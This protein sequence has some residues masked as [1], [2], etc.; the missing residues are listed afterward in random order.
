MTT[1]GAARRIEADAKSMRDMFRSADI[2][3]LLM[4][5]LQITRDEDLMMEAS[6]FIRGSWDFSVRMPPELT[7]RIIDRLASALERPDGLDRAKEPVPNDLLRRMM[8]LAVGQEVAEEYLPMARQQMG[9]DAPSV[10]DVLAAVP[11]S[12]KRAAAFPVVVIGAGLSGICAGIALKQAG[13]P[14][15]IIEKNDEVGGTW[16]ENVYPGAGVDTPSHF[17]SFSFDQKHDWT[18]FFPKRDEMYGYFRQLA[19]KHDLRSNIRFKTE[20]VDAVFD[21]AKSAWTVRCRAQAG[22]VECITARAVISAVG[23]LNRPSIPAIEGLDTFKGAKFHTAVWDKSQNISGKRVAMIGS[24][25]SAIQA[26]PK[27]AQEASHL[28]VFQRSPHWVVANPNYHRQINDDLQWVLKSVPFYA[29]WNR[30]RLFWSVADGIWPACVVDDSWSSP[31]SSV[32]ALSDRYRRHMT[33]YIESEVGDDPDLL[34][35]VIPN[36]PPYGKRMLVDTHWFR[37]LRRDNVSLVDTPIARIAENGIVTADGTLHEADILV[38][39]TGFKVSQML[40]PMEIRG[41]NGRSLNDAWN[42]DDPRAYLG[43][44]VPNFPN[45]FLLFGPNTGLS[46]GGSVIF[47]TERQVRYI[48][49]CLRELI[50][51]DKQV[52]EIKDDVF[53][54]YNVKVDEILNKTVWAHHKVH[55][56]YKNARGRVFFNSPWRLVDYWKLTDKPELDDYLIN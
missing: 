24:G 27:I 2:T 31:D 25:A 22:E 46:H 9:F 54:D 56:W 35:K 19:D 12:E 7:D 29:Q 50:E 20:V 14:F 13:L 4:V 39:A 38:L 40:S 47:H 51:N 10:K 43:M 11:L 45:F 55:S 5:L 26:G 17:Y 42:G 6:P 28:T 52:I 37:M 21:E 16:Y 53:N 3:C 1:N 34:A 30:F 32:N 41:R 49:Q 44:T 36:Y 18:T 15:T 48:M 33:S 23:Q 8:S